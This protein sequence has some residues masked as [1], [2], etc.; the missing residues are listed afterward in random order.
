VAEEERGR[1][2][3]AG[4]EG[5]PGGRDALAADEPGREPA[6]ASQAADGVEPGT[7]NQAGDGVQ[8]GTAAAGAGASGDAGATSATTAYPGHEPA[9]RRRRGG[10][11][12]GLL[13]R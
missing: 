2:G 13:R 4:D 10:L 8:P 11:L 1:D 7:A 9:V 3:L 6:T 5:G 12:S